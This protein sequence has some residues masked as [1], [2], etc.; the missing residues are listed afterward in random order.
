MITVKQATELLRI[1]KAYKQNARREDQAE[2]H[3]ARASVVKGYKIETLY[4]KTEKQLDQ[5]FRGALL[6]LVS[7]NLRLSKG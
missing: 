7:D 2:A 3:Y 6:T 4:L 1:A 5:K